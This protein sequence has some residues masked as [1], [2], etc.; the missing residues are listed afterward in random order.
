MAQVK[1]KEGLEKNKYNMS[2]LS[3][4]KFGFGFY[5]AFLTGTLIVFGLAV[6]IYYCL[7]AVG[8]SF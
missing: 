2:V 1:I 4:F 7:K 6:V 3:G 8:V 5:V